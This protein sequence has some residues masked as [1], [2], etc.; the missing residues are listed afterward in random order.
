MQDPVLFVQGNASVRNFAAL[1]TLLSNLLRCWYGLSQKFVED[2]FQGIGE[3]LIS[4]RLRDVDIGVFVPL[5]LKNLLIVLFS[6]VGNCDWDPVA[7]AA[8]ISD[9]PISVG[10]G[11]DVEW[12]LVLFHRNV[13]GSVWL[14]VSRLRDI[15][16][17][18][19][20]PDSN[21]LLWLK[22]LKVVK[23]GQIISMSFCSYFEFCWL[24]IRSLQNINLRFDEYFENTSPCCTSTRFKAHT[25]SADITCYHRW[26]GTSSHRQRGH[27]GR[28]GVQRGTS[29][30]LEGS[31]GTCL[32]S[33]TR[34]I[35]LL[36]L[37]IVG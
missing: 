10:V 8:P 23:Y 25:C 13:L 20:P 33:I 30:V 11:V 3:L 5:P 2:D 6:D 19:P 4:T 35:I 26:W 9:W 34:I 27:S 24:L 28:R 14:F 12:L 32:R 15:G 21:L 18:V 17:F 36:L 16:V 1:S 31:E 7:L 22:V 37:M 29:G